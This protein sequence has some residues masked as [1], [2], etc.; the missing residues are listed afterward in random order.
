MDTNSSKLTITYQPVGTLKHNSHNSRTHSKRQIRQIAD[1]IKAFGF[2]NPILVD[3]A[4]TII[5][6]HGRVSAAKLLGVPEVPTIRREDLSPDQ[7][8]AYGNQ[9]GKFIALDDACT[10]GLLND[11]EFVFVIDRSENVITD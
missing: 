10:T 6:G 7:I 2:T 5:A 11:S 8:R 1:S 4:N 3:D 9:I